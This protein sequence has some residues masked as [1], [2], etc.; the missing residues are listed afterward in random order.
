MSYEGTMRLAREHPES[1]GIIDVDWLS[2][3]RGCYEEAREVQS[4]GGDKFPGA[5]IR[6]RVGWFPGLIVLEK[7]GVLRPVGEP[8]RHG[9]RRY[10]VMPDINGVARPLR[11]LGYL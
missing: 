3:V 8:T 1:R 6:H 7:Y 10:W 9:S 2:V 4:R 11:E 5:R